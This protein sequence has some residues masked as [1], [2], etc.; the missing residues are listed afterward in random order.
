MLGIDKNWGL[1]SFEALGKFDNIH[2]IY[3]LDAKVGDFS[4]IGLEK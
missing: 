2:A 1:I 4:L 3:F